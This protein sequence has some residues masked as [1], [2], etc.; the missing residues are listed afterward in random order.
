[1]NF[2]IEYFNSSQD[3]SISVVPILYSLFKLSFNILKYYNI[4]LQI[5]FDFENLLEDL[6]KTNY[7]FKPF[8]HQHALQRDI[9]ILMRYFQSVEISQ[10]VLFSLKEK[11]FLYRG[12]LERLIDY[13]NQIINLCLW[14]AETRDHW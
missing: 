5:L 13:E 10:E 4:N 14:R 3:I 12:S 2:S 9:D 1:M 7:V 8:S 11:L 6:L